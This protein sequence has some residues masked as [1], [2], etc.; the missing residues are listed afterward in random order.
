M[1]AINRRSNLFFRSFVSN[2]F[3]HPL[4]VSSLVLLA[5]GCGNSS[6]VSTVTTPTATPETT[7]PAESP[8]ASTPNASPANSAENAADNMLISARGIGAARLGM[9]LGD[10]KD[11]LGTAAEFTVESP[12]ITD[13]DAIAVRKNGEVAYYVLYLAGEPPTDTDVIQGLLTNNP[14]FKTAEG[15][16]VGTPIAEAEEVYGS[17]NLSYNTLNE[18]REYARFE[19]QPTKNISFATGNGNQ[20]P[21]GIYAEPIGEYNETQNFREDAVI[22]SVLVICLSEECAP[23]ASN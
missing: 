7:A 13:F 14:D 21:A 20:D 23:P 11:T 19:Q 1:T 12:F 3:I 9:T 18:S 6:S 4:L 17:A 15:V 8:T 22:Q 2:S 10:L 5:T 16:G